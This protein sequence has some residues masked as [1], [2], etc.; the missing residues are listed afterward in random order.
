[1]LQSSPQ[2]SSC[3]FKIVFIFT[4]ISVTTN[5][6]LVPPEKLHV[7][8]TE[9]SELFLVVVIAHY[10]GVAIITSELFMSLEMVN[11]LTG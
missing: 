7:I 11:L 5:N 8:E 1:M 2:H 4:I 9:S 6:W 10:L 3:I